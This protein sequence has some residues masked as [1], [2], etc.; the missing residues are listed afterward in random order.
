[1]I[2][3]ALSAVLTPR[4]ASGRIHRRRGMAL[5]L[6]ICVLALLMAF[7]IAAQTAVMGSIYLIAQSGQRQI[8]AR[9]IDTALARAYQALKST[10]QDSGSLQIRGKDDAPI[11][12]SYERLATGGAVYGALPGIESHRDGDALVDIA[13]EENAP[14]HR[15]LINLQGRR[16]GALRIQ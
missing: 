15:F 14:Q 2:R 12:V 6:A 13:L 4:G 8:A 3:S 9:Q 16:T 10:T 5:V 1:M 11:V 7:L